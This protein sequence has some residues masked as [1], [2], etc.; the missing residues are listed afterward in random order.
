[1][2]Q[3]DPGLWGAATRLIHS[4]QP[5]AISGV[6][7]AE[8]AWVLLRHYGVPRDV[9]V[10]RLTRLLLLPN[11]T[12]LGIDKALAVEALRRCAAS[13]RVSFADA[14]INA[15]HRGHGVTTLYTFDRRFPAEG[16]DL[17]EPG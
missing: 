7:L 15:D 8:T 1:L 14:L 3:D 2:L 12:V 16:L 13:A 9:V 11:V 5:L 17:R 6:A 4:D 10:D